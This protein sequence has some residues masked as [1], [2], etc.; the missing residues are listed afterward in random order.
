MASCKANHELVEPYTLHTN[1]IS[2]A[3]MQSF[4]SGTQFFNYAKNVFGVLYRESD[5]HGLSRPEMLSIDLHCCLVEL[6]ARAAVL[7]R[8][9]N[10]AKS[11]DQTWITRRIDIANHWR[12]AQPFSV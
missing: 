11:R 3:A 9:L 1:G 6:P 10:H 5:P 4:N 7:A 2:F 8:F 12:T